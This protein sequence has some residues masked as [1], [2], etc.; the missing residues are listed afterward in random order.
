ME[1]KLSLKKQFRTVPFINPK[2]G[3]EV[4]IGSPEYYKLVKKYGEPYKIKS[5]KSQ[6]MISVG[7]GAYINLIKSG[8]SDKQL[9][10]GQYDV[11]TNNNTYNNTNNNN[12]GDGAYNNTNNNTNNITLVDDVTLEIFN[13]LSTYDKLTFCQVNKK[14]L[15]VCNHDKNVS[16]LKFNQHQKIIKAISDTTF[17]SIIDNKLYYFT[18]NGPAQQKINIPL[19][20]KIIPI[21]VTI[22]KDYVLLLTNDG[23]YNM[24]TKKF[25]KINQPPG[26]ILQIHGLEDICVILTSTGLYNYDFKN[27]ELIIHIENA[28]FMYPTSKIYYQIAAPKGLYIVYDKTAIHINIDNINDILFIY[29]DYVLTTTGLYYVKDNYNTV[30]ITKLNIP[31]VKKI[32][33]Q[34]G[35]LLVLTNDNILTLITNHGKSK[36]ISSDVIDICYPIILHND[37]THTFITQK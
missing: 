35:K 13:H 26:K 34:R 9:I 19:P 12:T 11:V 30:S 28:Y 3:T 1:P 37:N 22:V 29:K 6:K 20:P 5:L 23:L 21:G 7:K 16:I 10:L 18:Y 24:K 27:Y 32:S 33:G 8:Y 15:D 4:V 31:N 14:F 2:T 25:I 17:Y 36:P